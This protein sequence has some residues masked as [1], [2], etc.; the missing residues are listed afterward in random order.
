[1]PG[2]L[3][4]CRGRALVVLVVLHGRQQRQTTNQVKVPP[5][6]KNSSFEIGDELVQVDQLHKFRAIESAEPNA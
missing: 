4:L 1:M 6:T 2:E 3:A 5:I